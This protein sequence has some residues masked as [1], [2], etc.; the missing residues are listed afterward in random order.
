MA[1][2]AAAAVAGPAAA[3]P[4]SAG[5]RT[6]RCDPA[7][8]DHLRVVGI[9]FILVVFVTMVH[10]PMAALLAEMFPTRVRCTS[11]SLPYH[12]GNGWFGGVLPSAAFAIFASTGN[13]YSGLCYP[14][15]IALAGCVVGI[16]FVREARHVDLEAVGR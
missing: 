5:C 12:I 14:I 8:I 13:M 16:V 15:A 9:L 6:V 4:P 3:T 11:V 2:Q 1:G 7:R 10:G